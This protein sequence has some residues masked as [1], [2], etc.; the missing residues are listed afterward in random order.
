MTRRR[1][2]GTPR[3]AP[4][5]HAQGAL[6]PLPSLRP[7][8]ARTGR[9]SSPPVMTRR[10]RCG[11]PQTGAEVLTLK[12]HTG[13]VVSASFSPDGSRVVTASHDKTA[14][15]W[16][17]ADRRRGPH[18]QG[19]HRSGNFSSSFSPDGSRDRHRQLLTAANV[20]DAKTQREVFTLKGHTGPVTRHRSAQTGRGSSPPA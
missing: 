11:T 17:A 2:C 12:G 10:R 4:S 18:A 9:G 7:R 16:D 3:P 6:R 15:V 8:S 5:P 19:A 14:K 1:R 13:H 20:W